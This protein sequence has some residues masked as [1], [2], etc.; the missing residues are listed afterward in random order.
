MAP[1][2]PHLLIHPLPLNEEVKAELFVNKSDGKSL[3]SDMSIAT[4]ASFFL[5]VCLEN[6]FPALHFQSV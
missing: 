6:L 3:L 1:K 2:D 5:S 4:P